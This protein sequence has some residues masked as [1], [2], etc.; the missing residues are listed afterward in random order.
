MLILRK[1][2]SD[3]ENNIEKSPKLNREDYKRIGE[4]VGTL[5]IGAAGMYGASGLTDKVSNLM[6]KDQ[7]RKAVR[8]YLKKRREMSNARDFHLKKLADV[9]KSRNIDAA[10]K[11]SDAVE[12]HN[13]S[14]FGKMGLVREAEENMKRVNSEGKVWFNNNKNYIDKSYNINSKKARD[15]IS[16]RR[17]ENIS[18][19][20]KGAK[21]T[22]LG[23]L[24]TGTILTGL[25][26][27][28]K[29]KKNKKEEE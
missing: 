17:N 15:I 13:K 28:S 6:V 14:L 16:K 24:A 18:K 1:Y 22:K 21:K 7:K 26:A 29:L 9:V 8:D 25:S 19:I 11:Y 10:E 12:R 5:G 4:A 20:S 27:A 3:D 23:L 2:F